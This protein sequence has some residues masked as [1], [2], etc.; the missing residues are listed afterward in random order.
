[1]SKLNKIKSGKENDDPARL[2]P[3]RTGGRG[4]HDSSTFNSLT[5]EKQVIWMAARDESVVRLSGVS[6]ALMLPP[7]TM[8]RWTQKKASDEVA[9]L[10]ELK[11]TTGLTD[12]QDE[13]L[14]RALKY[15]A[16]CKRA[17]KTSRRLFHERQVLEDQAEKQEATLREAQRLDAEAQAEA[18]SRTAIAAAEATAA[19]NAAK[20]AAELK[21]V[22]TQKD[23]QEFIKEQQAL[24]DLQDKADHDAKMQQ[25]KRAKAALASKLTADSDAHQAIMRQMVSLVVALLRFVAVRPLTMSAL[26]GNGSRGGE[27]KARHR[28]GK[29]GGRPGRRN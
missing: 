26:P 10:L 17:Q 23:L 3:K 1:M 21:A 20:K 28:S 8:R 2:V 25:L 6:F 11:K 24:Q 29:G 18:D 7:L 16:E 4:R 9:E 27:E 19:L 14:T 5:P 12:E 22:E 13:A 15:L